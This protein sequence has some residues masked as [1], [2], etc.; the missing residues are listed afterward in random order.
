MQEPHRLAGACYVWFQQMI[1]A[2]SI[3]VLHSTVLDVQYSTNIYIIVFKS[4][5]QFCASALCTGLHTCL[6]S[7]LHL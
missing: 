5:L 3:R 4:G 7:G 1:T 6:E 2:V